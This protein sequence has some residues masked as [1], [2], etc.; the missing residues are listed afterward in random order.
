MES[1]D[2][3]WIIVFIVCLLILGILKQNEKRANKKSTR[4][5]NVNN[6]I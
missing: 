5:I 3:I 2:A 1:E 6:F 4:H